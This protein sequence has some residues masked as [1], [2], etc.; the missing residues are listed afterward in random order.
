MVTR[1]WWMGEALPHYKLVSAWGCT[2]YL[3]KEQFY[4]S[5]IYEILIKKDRQ[6][7]K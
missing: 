3:G 7:K 5:K 1:G 6:V 4:G 2:Y